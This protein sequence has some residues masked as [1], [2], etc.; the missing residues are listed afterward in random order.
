MKIKDNIVD[1]LLKGLA[2]YKPDLK[3]DWDSFY[4]DY[5][6]NITNTTG[7]GNKI[8]GPGT[9]SIGLKSVIIT[10]VAL[11]GILA[12]YFLFFDKTTSTGSSTNHQTQD[13]PAVSDENA[14]LP[15]TTIIPVM[16]NSQSGIEALNSTGLKQNSILD[17]SASEM[18]TNTFSNSA[19]S[20]PVINEP[21]IDKSNTSPI[22]GDEIIHQTGDSLSDEPIIIKKTVI[23]T[24]TVKVTRPHKKLNQK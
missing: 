16:D 21:I 3:P 10:I 15:N 7:S 19:S 23:I 18:N 14:A 13:S 11:S 2:D 24:D 22:V 9:V 6:K 17:N 12:G 20:E 1:D 5:Q 4:A 8:S